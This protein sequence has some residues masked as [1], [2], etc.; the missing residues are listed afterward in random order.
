MNRLII[1]TVISCSL[2]VTPCLATGASNATKNLKNEPKLV[3]GLMCG[4]TPFKKFTEAEAYGR[5]KFLGCAKI[6]SK[7]DTKYFFNDRG[8]LYQV[9]RSCNESEIAAFSKK[10]GKPIIRKRGDATY[11]MEESIW[12]GQNVKISFGKQTVDANGVLEK[13]CFLLYACI[14]VEHSNYDCNNLETET[15]K[16]RVDSFIANLGVDFTNSIH[17]GTD[18]S[19]LEKYIESTNTAAVKMGLPKPHSIEVGQAM[20][21]PQLCLKYETKD[22]LPLKT[23]LFKRIGDITMN[24]M[25]DSLDY[26]GKTAYIS[27]FQNKKSDRL[28]MCINSR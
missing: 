18:N 20:G 2:T 22:Y 27:T 6:Y 9:D 25:F 23:A 8:Q 19:D 24:Y 17:K 10:H 26:D 1:Y 21:I 16:E 5:P 14:N 12:E 28:D 13:K 11:E 4:D 15:Q 7:N 3:E